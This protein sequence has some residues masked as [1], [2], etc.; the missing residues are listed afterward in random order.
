M[1]LESKFCITPSQ[2]YP[3][4]TEVPTW[5]VLILLGSTFFIVKNIYDII[6]NK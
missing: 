5:V 4:K 2:C 1:E 6:I 3:V